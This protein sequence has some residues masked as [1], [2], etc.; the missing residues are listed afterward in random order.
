MENISFV[1]IYP[2]LL[3]QNRF[4]VNC[5]FFFKKSSDC[6][7]LIDPVPPIPKALPLFWSP[8]RNGTVAALLKYLQLHDLCALLLLSFTCH[9][10]VG[11]SF[12]CNTLDSPSCLWCQKCPAYISFISVWMTLWQI[13]ITKIHSRRCRNLRTF[14]IQGVSRQE[15]LCVEHNFHQVLNLNSCFQ[16]FSDLQLSMPSGD[17]AMAS[18]SHF[19]RHSW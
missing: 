6:S 5:F 4:L 1:H 11:R 3:G 13:V 8:F 17:K 2:N 14:Y 19:K 10:L 7:Q 16:L 9:F 12:S 15:A 18:A